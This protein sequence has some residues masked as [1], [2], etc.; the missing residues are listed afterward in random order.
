MDEGGAPGREVLELRIA[1]ERTL[2]GR[3]REA[4]EATLADLDEALG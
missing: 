2:R 4:I 1:M 3:I